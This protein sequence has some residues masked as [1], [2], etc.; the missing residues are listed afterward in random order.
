MGG[1]VNYILGT[2]E[3]CLGP[4]DIGKGF[5]CYLTVAPNGVFYIIDTESGAI[6]EGHSV[7]EVRKHVADAEVAVMRKQIDELIEH[8]KKVERVDRMEFWRRMKALP[9]GE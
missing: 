4:Y 9:R 7:E 1:N 8:A 6:A 2:E 3:D 5:S